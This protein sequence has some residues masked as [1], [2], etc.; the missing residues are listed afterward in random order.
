MA[1]VVRIDINQPVRNGDAA[2]STGA[3]APTAFARPEPD[4]IPVPSGANPLT[5]GWVTNLNNRFLVDPSG[6][7]S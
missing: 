1:T 5:L 7:N 2:V 6:W 4:V 3:P